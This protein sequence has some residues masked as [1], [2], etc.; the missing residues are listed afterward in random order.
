[1]VVGAKDDEL[2]MIDA[3]NGTLR[4][5]VNVGTT[6]DTSPTLVGDIAYVVTRAGNVMAFD[7]KQK[8]I[9]FQKAAWGIWFQF[10]VWNMA[11]TP[12]PPPGLI[13][14]VRIRESVRGDLATDGERLFVA[15]TAG[16]LRAFDLD[17][18]EVIWKVE[19]LDK[20]RS[21]P[22][23]SGDTVVQVAED[24]TVIGVD[25]AT[26]ERLWSTTVGEGVLASAVLAG[27]TLYV[28]TA[29]GTLLALR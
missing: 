13:W 10:W 28:P 2:Y 6:V 15:T 12:A 3:S 7:Y 18:G 29:E 27:G 16:V 23:V 24:G 25:A 21:S 17:T 22:I 8:D 1:V 20:I 9:P 19:G 5:Q 26:G 4:Y 11:P 14:G